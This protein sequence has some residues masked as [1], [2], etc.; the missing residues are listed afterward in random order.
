MCAYSLIFPRNLIFC[1]IY[2]D[3]EIKKL[4]DLLNTK[5]VQTLA[6]LEKLTF[7]IENLFIIMF[8]AGLIVF[9]L[10]YQ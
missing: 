2:E 4:N 10:S 8:I 3:P 5:A 6:E 9:V 7:I 1:R